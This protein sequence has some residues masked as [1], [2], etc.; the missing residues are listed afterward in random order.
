LQ[1]A[2]GVVPSEVSVFWA[3]QDLPFVGREWI[4]KDDDIFLGGAYVWKNLCVSV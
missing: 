4:P 3:D 1:I 2:Y